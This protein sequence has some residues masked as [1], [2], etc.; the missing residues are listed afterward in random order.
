MGIQRIDEMLAVGGLQVN[1]S[2]KNVTGTT[3]VG[4][5]SDLSFGATGKITTLAAALR[6]VLHIPNQAMAGGGVYTPLQS[7]VY[8]DG[9]ASDPA[10]MTTLAFIRVLAS[11]D[12]SGIADVDDDAVLLS[13]E[14]LSPGSGNMISAA[15]DEPTW[16]GKTRQI[17][18]KLPGGGLTYLVAVD[19]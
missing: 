19:P 7:E 14:G 17:R 6:S 3:V 1:H 8:S 16:T 13:I 12:A 2:Q 11:G 4:A 5:L 15:G 9:S 10:G 18:C